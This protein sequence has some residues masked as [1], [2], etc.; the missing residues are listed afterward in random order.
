MKPDISAG[1]VQ[2]L[3]RGRRRWECSCGSV[4]W[5]SALCDGITGCCCGRRG[6]CATFEVPVCQAAS[7]GSRDRKYDRRPS[8]GF[9]ATTVLL[10]RP[11]F[12]FPSPP[13]RCGGTKG[14][15]SPAVTVSA[16]YM[17]HTASS[18]RRVHEST[19]RRWWWHGSW[20]YCYTAPSCRTW[21]RIRQPGLG[22]IDPPPIRIGGCCWLRQW[23]KSDLER[24]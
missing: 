22:A 6:A 11:L 18:G 24:V 5:L 2:A 15:M 14:G 13:G 16:T 3:Q 8:P 9:P 12:S 1:A 20:R 17:I 7:T 10:L 23:R 21:R 4:W 19:G